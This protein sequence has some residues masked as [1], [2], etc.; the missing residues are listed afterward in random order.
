MTS[1]RFHQAGLSLIELMI[2]VALGL[3]L[4]AGAMQIF[5]SNTQAFRLQDNIS[6][7]QESGRLGI[8]V[9]LNDLRRAGVDY[10]R[11]IATTGLLYAVTGKNNSATTAANPGLLAN[12]DEVT[13]T[14]RVPAEVGSMSDC[15]GSVIATGGLIINRYFVQMDTNPAIP[16]LFC[17]G[18]TGVATA[19]IRGVESFQ[20]QYGV[21]DI[22]AN[23][24]DP[25]EK[26]SN[27]FA[28]PNR[29]VVGEAAS[30][31]KL[32]VASIRVGLLVRSEA[33][34]QGLNA[35]ANAIAVL[36]STDVT[37]AA[38]AGVKVGGFFPVHRYFTG[39]AILRNNTYGT[40]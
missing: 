14:Y 5:L 8:E 28:S 15:E 3:L 11:D 34:I 30:G 19:L 16:A 4:V 36:D 29:Y 25:T 17:A 22:P 26:T 23:G 6:S 18:K 9:L 2:S 7:A 10:S 32:R 24:V 13:I 12:S 21:A 20:V 37:Q 35:P 27:G 1:S 38:L 40:F 31:A 33:G 39:S